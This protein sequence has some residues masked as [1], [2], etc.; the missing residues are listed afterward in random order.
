[1]QPPFPSA[2]A[3]WRN[4]TYAAISPERPELSASGKTVVITGAGSG[5]GRETAIAFATAGAAR[6]ALLGR[7][8]ASLNQTAAALPSTVSA[9]VHVVD[10]A[11]EESLAQ[12]AA[13]IGTWD[14]LILAA[15]HVA[16]PSTIASSNFAEFW[17]SFETN[18][19]GTY[20]SLHAFLPTAN[21]AHA[22][23]LA[24]TTGTATLPATMVPGLSAYMAS[25]L[26]QTKLIEFLA[27]EHS[28]LFAATVHPG[29]IETSIFTRSGAKAESLPMD[30]VQLPAHFMVWLASPEAAFLNGRQVWANWDVDE[31]K[32]KADAIK[33]SQLYTAGINGW[34]FTP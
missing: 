24:V 5:I 9:S 26:A 29:M 25:K 10:V 7:T 3:N 16:S 14:V 28:N 15:G 34:P 27:A 32:A 23:V 12:A 20:A 2:T 8:E 19:K 11:S 21:T 1:M 18:T 31:L 6:V 17:Q 22:A 30:K 13:A 4:D 33:Q